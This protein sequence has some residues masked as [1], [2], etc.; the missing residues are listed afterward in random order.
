V[1]H[2]YTSEACVKKLRLSHEAL[3]KQPF[4]KKIRMRIGTDFLQIYPRPQVRQ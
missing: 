3:S 1:G 4:F 2:A